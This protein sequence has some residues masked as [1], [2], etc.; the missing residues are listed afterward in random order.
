MV[1]YRGEN[2]PGYNQPKR[3]PASSEKKWRVLAKDGARIG[4]VE[5]GARGY[6]DYTQ[7]KDKGRRAN[8]RARHNC[9][10]KTDK[11][12]AGYWA[13]KKLW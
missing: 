7:H 9:A 12:T 11:L 8:F 4:V 6:E 5:F 1:E 13:C 2:F 10:D 3:A